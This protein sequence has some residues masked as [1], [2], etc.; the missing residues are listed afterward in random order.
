MEKKHVEK[1]F[2]PKLLE[3]DQPDRAWTLDRLGKFAR[4]RHERI[5]A[6]ERQLAPIYWALGRALNIA[7]KQIGRIAWGNQR[8]EWGISKTTAFR[9]I[10]IFRTFKTP[11]KLG[12]MTVEE[13]FEERKR[14][15]VHRPHKRRGKKESVSAGV[16]AADQAG[17]EEEREPLK[18]FLSDTRLRADELMNAAATATREQRKELVQ[19]YDAA[20]E[21]LQDLGRMLGAMDQPR[22]IEKTAKKPGKHA[23]KSTLAQVSAK[24]TPAA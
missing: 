19:L 18:A 23:I 9:A 1:S 20:M 17:Q 6:G 24:V 11:E 4:E 13:A 7:R 5:L 8:E 16:E 12:N 14:R 22:P 3:G 10:S 21:R 2:G 15:Q